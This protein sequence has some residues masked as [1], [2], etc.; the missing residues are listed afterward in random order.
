MQRWDPPV[1]QAKI[2]PDKK[3]SFCLVLKQ[4]GIPVLC[5]NRKKKCVLICIALFS[6]PDDHCINQGKI[7]M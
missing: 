2:I 3:K 5:K 6:I 4:V 7:K 1:Y